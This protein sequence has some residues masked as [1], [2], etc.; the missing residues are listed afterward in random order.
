MGVV[1]SSY[2]FGRDVGIWVVIWNLVSFGKLR[3]FSFFS[4]GVFVGN[5]SFDGENFIK[6][7]GGWGGVC[8]MFFFLGIVRFWDF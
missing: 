1:L 8:R 6:W 5:F 7:M 3:D 2:Y 4:F